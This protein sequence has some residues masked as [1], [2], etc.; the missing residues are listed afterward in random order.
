VEQQKLSQL[1]YEEEREILI[2]VKYVR[3]QNV[4]VTVTEVPIIS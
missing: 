3:R 2:G 1:S 4:V